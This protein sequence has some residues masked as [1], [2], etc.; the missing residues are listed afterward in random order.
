MNGRLCKTLVIDTFDWAEQ[1]CI[2]MI[3]SAH[4]K[5]GIE[6]FGYG[7]GYVYEKRR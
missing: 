1:L 4:Q 6:D 2:E 5:K 7:N 3:C